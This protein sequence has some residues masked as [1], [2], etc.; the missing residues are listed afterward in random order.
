MIHGKRAFLAGML[1]ATGAYRG[2]RHLGPKSLVILNYHRI[3]A[4]DGT[5]SPFD[6]GVFGPTQEILH[7]HLHWLKTNSS[8]ISEP[9]LIDHVTKKRRLPGSAVMITFD[10]GYRD[11]ADLAMPVLEDLKVPATF[12]ISTRAIESREL[13]WWDAIAYA[14]KQSTLE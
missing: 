10:D 1:H 4:S 8:I 7:E 3:R 5:V 13:G 6:E 12:F 14:I 9:E 11:N 2:F